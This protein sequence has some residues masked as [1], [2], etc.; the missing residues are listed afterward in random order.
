MQL[1]FCTFHPSLISPILS[2]SKNH[3]VLNA[4]YLKQ[5]AFRSVSS[6]ADPALEFGE[7]HMEGIWGSGGVAP[8]KI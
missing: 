7:G 1:S 8:R 6:G 4:R 3:V 5:V 2:S